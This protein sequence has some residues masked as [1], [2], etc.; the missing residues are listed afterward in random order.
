[1]PLKLKPRESERYFGIQKM[2]KYQTGSD[3]NRAKPMA[4]TSLD[5][6]IPAH[7]MGLFGSR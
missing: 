7:G 5:R 6:K 3:K 4:Q 1:M 2:K